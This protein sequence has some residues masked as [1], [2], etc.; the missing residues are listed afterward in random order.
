M[1]SAVRLERGAA[2]RQSASRGVPHSSSPP[3]RAWALSGPSPFSG[4][5]FRC[6]LFARCP[7]ASKPGPAP[8]AWTPRPDASP[9]RFLPGVG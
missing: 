2:F 5:R 7:T 9:G 3:P 1:A 8:S 6:F 4:V